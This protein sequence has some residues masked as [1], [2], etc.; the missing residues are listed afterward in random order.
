MLLR[1]HRKQWESNKNQNPCSMLSVRGNLHRVL[2]KIENRTALAFY[3]FFFCELRK[4]VFLE[5]KLITAIKFKKANY[6]LN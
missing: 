3:F 6:N 1:Q 4:N 2:G 5:T